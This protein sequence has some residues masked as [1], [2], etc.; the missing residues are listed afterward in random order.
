[1]IMNIIICIFIDKY[2]INEVYKLDSRKLD[3]F[4]TNN[5]STFILRTY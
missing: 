5:T 1:M 4:F 2:R 3:E